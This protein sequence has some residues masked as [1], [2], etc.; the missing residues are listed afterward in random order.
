[1]MS[2]DRVAYDL[3]KAKTTKSHNIV[4]VKKKRLQ[5]MIPLPSYFQAEIITNLKILI[6]QFYNFFLL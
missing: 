3:N 5:K 2:G 1:M 4:F 6:W